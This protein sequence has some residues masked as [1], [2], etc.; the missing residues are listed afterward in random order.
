MKFVRWGL[1]AVLIAIGISI[2]VRA[3]QDWRTA[4]RSPVGLAPDPA[5]T[6]EAVVQVYGAR[7]YSWRGVFGVHTWI[8]VKPT[9]APRYTVVEVIGWRAYRG[10]DAVAVSH[11]PPDGR[12]FGSAPE[13]LADHRGEGVDQMIRDIENAV[14]A[15]PYRNQY[16]V[17]PGP[18][19]NTFI[20]HVIRNT[21]G[22]VAD[23]PP[24]AIGKDYLH[25]AL[26]DQMPS[27][28]GYQLSAWGLLG[29]SLALEEGIEVNILGLTFGID[30]D[31][32][33]IK[34]PLLGKV[35]L[36]DDRG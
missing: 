14:L 19:S 23:L 27:K 29:I 30:P 5:T 2:S 9:N 12:W 21:P 24:T 36:R 17:W 22:L 35:S 11:R 31:S 7:A 1:L 15:Y 32:Q 20:A 33:G 18:N 6:R 16:R 34:L 3:G 25:D 13:L 10:G 8:A 4:D 28:T 26:F